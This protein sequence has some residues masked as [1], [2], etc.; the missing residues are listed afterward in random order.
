MAAPGCLRL[1]SGRFLLDL[2]GFTL[3][4][5]VSGVQ[6]CKSGERGGAMLHARDLS[7]RL[8]QGRRLLLAR[9]CAAAPGVSVLD[10]TA[11]FGLDGL[12]LA[13]LGCSVTLC[14]RDPLVFELLQD[15]VGRLGPTE[16]EEGEAE[17]VHAE[18]RDFLREPRRYDVVYLD[19]IFPERG[20][21][22][23][24]GKRARYLA[25]L[26]G[27]DTEALEELLALAL[28][29]AKKRVVVKRRRLDPEARKPDFVIQ[30]RSVRFDVYRAG[31]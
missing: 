12:T 14:E 3:D 30:G 21:T 15:G 20:K 16:S 10:A 5:T 6:L 17:V 11:G 9:A 28:A 25:E 8:Q 29:R 2:K 1:A 4:R 18:A 23:L 7:R 22:A 19:P 13:A 31:A 27:H 26:V 24:P